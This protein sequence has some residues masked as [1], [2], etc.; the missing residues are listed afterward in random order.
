MNDIRKV[1][2]GAIA[3]EFIALF[4]IVSPTVLGVADLLD[5]EIMM[6]KTYTEIPSMFLFLHK[7]NNIFLEPGLILSTLIG[8]FGIYSVEKFLIKSGFKDAPPSKAVVWS[9]LIFA[10]L[11]IPKIAAGVNFLDALDD[12]MIN[13][14][15]QAFQFASM[16]KG[17]SALLFGIA[18]IIVSIFLHRFFSH[19]AVSVKGKSPGKTGARL[20]FW[21]VIFGI[22]VKTLAVYYYPQI[23][24][25]AF[26]VSQMIKSFGLSFISFHLFSLA[27]NL[28]G[29]NNLKFN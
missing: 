3:F 14:N 22:A 21:S 27:Y 4:G 16:L 6:G 11:R 5:I 19:Q 25:A 7:L 20:I 28:S 17:L 24:S 18:A 1:Y 13:K 26:I 8:A 9:L 2:L 23:L 12:Y 29:E 10:L 15:F